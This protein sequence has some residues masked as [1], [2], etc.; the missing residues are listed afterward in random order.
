VI[1]QI[2]SKK[3]WKEEKRTD[4]IESTQ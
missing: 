1:M 4:Q 2:K 3:N